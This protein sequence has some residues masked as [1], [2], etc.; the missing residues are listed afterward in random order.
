ML[1]NRWAF[2]GPFIRLV[3]DWVENED[4]WAF[5]EMDVA[6]GW[7]GSTYDFWHYLDG[8][9]KVRV[10]SVEEIWAWLLECEKRSDLALFSQRDYWQHPLTF[11]HLR[12]GDCED[13]ALW[14]WRK[15]G[16]LGISA[17]FFTGRWQWNGEVGTE[18]RLHAW[19]TFQHDGSEY[20][21]ESMAHS[22][23]DMVGPLEGAKAEYTPHLSVGHVRD[24]RVYGGFV[25]Y[26]E[27]MKKNRGRLWSGDPYRPLLGE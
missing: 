11:E 20:L 23:D 14:A 22:A 7:F 6:P 26:R 13:H 25:Q 2:S 9:S 17:R 16:E 1:R 8:D 3:A 10:G 19:V 4:V 27:W 21:V 5:Q 15:L 12:M 18:P 24:T